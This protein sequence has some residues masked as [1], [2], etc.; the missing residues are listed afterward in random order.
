[1]QSRRCTF[2]PHGR[3]VRTTHCSGAQSLASFLDPAGPAG[4]PQKMDPIRHRWGNPDDPSTAMPRF[5]ELTTDAPTQSP[6]TRIFSDRS[7][8]R[9]RSRSD[10]SDPGIYRALSSDTARVANTHVLG[11][12]SAMRDEKASLGSKSRVARRIKNDRRSY[13]DGTNEQPS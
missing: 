7:R 11:L 4:V 6:Q 10:T 2:D 9:E 5:C 12:F 13:A 8:A 3:A 1:M